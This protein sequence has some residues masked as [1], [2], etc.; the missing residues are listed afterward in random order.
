M[1]ITFDSITILIWNFY[2]LFIRL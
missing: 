1:L 2:R